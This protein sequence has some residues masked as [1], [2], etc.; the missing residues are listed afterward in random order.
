M[1]LAQIGSVTSLPQLAQL[2]RELRRRQARQRGERE[3]TYR[4][5]AASTG[6]SIGALAGYF[7]GGILPPTD[8]F[9][10]LVTLLDA[11]P[12]E[13]GALA[14][15]RDR[16]SERRRAPSAAP[17]SGPAWPLP[18]Q[19]PPVGFPFA[20][21]SPQLRE[22]DRFVTGGAAVTPTVVVL[23]GT[24]GVGKTALATHWAHR[25]ADRF[26]DGQ[27]HVDLRGFAP[28]GAVLPADEAIRGFLDTF[29]VRGHRMPMTPVARVALYRSLIAHRRILIL[30]DNARDA[31]H[32]RPLLPGAPTSLVLVT[33]RNR[34]TS[35]VAV[36]GARPV[37]VDLL[38]RAEAHLLLAGR[39]GADRVAAEPD[40]VTEII[41]WCQHL[42]LALAVVAGRA[43]DQ[44]QL[45]LST[46]AGQLRDTHHRLDALNAGDSTGDVRTVLS[47]SY[48]ALSTPAA[49]LFRLFGLHPG[50]T[51]SAPALAS[52]AALPLHHTRTLLTELVTANLLT[53][54]IPGRYTSHDLL[55]VYATECAHQDETGADRHA[56]HHRLLDHY[57]HTAYAA[58]RLIDP[59]RT[60]AVPEPPRPHVAPEP[61][62]DQDLAW[63]WLSTEYP[64]LVTLIKI[65]EP[66]P[67]D[68]QLWYLSRA[69]AT[70]LY[71][72]AL[73]PDLAA[74]HR[75]AAD[76]AHRLADPAMESEALRILGGSYVYLGRY[77][78]A[79]RQLRQA[80]GLSARSGDRTAEAHGHHMLSVLCDAQDDAAEGLRHA[81]RC[82]E[83]HQGA[84]DRRNHAIAL[85]GVGWLLTRAG[86]HRQAIVRCQEAMAIHTELD[87][88][89]GIAGTLDSLGH[90]Y[91][92]LGDLDQAVGCFRRSIG[93][94]HEIGD[95][96][97]EAD[98]T[99]RLGDALQALGETIAASDAWLRALRE[100]EELGHPRADV[101]RTRLAEALTATRAGPCL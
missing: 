2:L 98:V 89:D 91:H 55:R 92:Q 77:D 97:L 36:D 31:D 85:A 84:G 61:F 83:L 59:T 17:A 81:E 96:Y 94:F 37:G 50:P 10:V 93:L 57:V 67:F 46:L 62:T 23:S 28:D 30:L 95:R 38:S 21:R 8:R 88:R 90:A 39:L 26:P 33:S 40:A 11:T 25:V 80:I 66:G 100:F 29:E 52:S 5:L 47:W 86:N 76:A 74:T 19:L 16:V 41:T 15:A 75:V 79:E 60:G 72:R 18:R 71:R 78:D 32:V 20:G 99:V 58:D 3:A 6:W 44:P 53:E 101:V 43:A 27:L 45:A 9:D 4:E 87:N 42:P 34:L 73:W 69:I 22:L 24:A 12:A 54:P 7:G 1:S 51:V 70:F 56:A 68:T 14:T 64:G 48:Q 35:L 49:R 13:R 65:A 63:A 82:L